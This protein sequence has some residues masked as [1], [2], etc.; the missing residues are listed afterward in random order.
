M[1]QDTIDDFQRHKKTTT[2]EA[3]SGE[4]QVPRTAEETQLV[5]RPSTARRIVAP[6]AVAV[7]LTFGIWGA[8]TVLDQQTSE[9]TPGVS[10]V[11]LAPAPAPAP[12][13]EPPIIV[14]ELVEI[15]AEVSYVELAIESTPASARVYRVSDGV[16][17]GRTPFT[18][19]VRK[20]TGSMTFLLRKTG[21]K[22]AKVVMPVAES[23]AKQ[24]RLDERSE[25]KGKGKGKGKGAKDPVEEPAEEPVKEPAEEPKAEAPVLP[26]AGTFIE[27]GGDSPVDP[28]GE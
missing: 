23:G 19:K 27:F 24:V 1:E 21:F 26:E 18:T 22:S 9:D 17:V 11:A 10:A 6:L 5:Q 28:S 8:W 12:A 13:A 15:P 20:G 14:R 16:E 4:Y 7:G 3:S 2:L 25:S